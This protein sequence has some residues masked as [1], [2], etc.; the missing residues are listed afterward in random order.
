MT[1]L[2]VSLLQQ[3]AATN[4]GDPWYGSSRAVLL[5]GLTAKDAAAHP[6]PGGHSIWELVLHM[7]S[8]TREVERRL[9]GAEPAEPEDGDWP[10]V[11]R[12]T[13]ARWRA[14]CDALVEANAA[15]L[16]AVAA[17]PATRWEA[18]VGGL[19]DPALGTGT[20][21]GGMLVGLAQHDAYHVGQLALLRHALRELRP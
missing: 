17:L 13:A 7:T 5:D 10:A 2:A 8:W 19:R 1:T 9:Q 11:G 21:I 16:K 15:L 6:I 3:I 20:T 12:P 18:P 4:Q 14:A